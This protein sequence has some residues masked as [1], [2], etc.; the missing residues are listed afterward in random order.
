VRIFTFLA[1]PAALLILAACGDDSDATLPD[2]DAGGLT[3]TETAAF[4]TQY[5]EHLEGRLPTEFPE[6]FPI[7]DGA[8]IA[9]GDTLGDRYAID[10]RT[11]AEMESVIDYYRSS[12][13][14]PPWRTIEEEP[15]DA[16]VIFTYESEDGAYSGEVAIGKLQERTWILIAMVPSE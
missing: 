4:P 9:R 10:L 3:V 14:T 1:L 7:Y 6:T 2:A 13:A 8:E 12:L 16:S 15:G 11:E 5:G